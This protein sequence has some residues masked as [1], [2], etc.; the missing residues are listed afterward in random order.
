MRPGKA[1]C[2][3]PAAFE[4]LDVPEAAAEVALEATEERDEA[5]LL[6]E[7]R[8]L[9]AEAEASEAIDD[10]DDAAP[11]AT[12]EAPEKM[13]VDP[14]IDVKVEP[15]EVMMDSMADVVTADPTA[16]VADATAEEALEAA[17]E[18]AEVT[19]APT[20]PAPK[21]VVEPTVEVE[22]A[23]S[24][25]RMS[26]VVMAED[27]SAPEEDPEDPEDPA[28]AAVSVTV[29]VERAEVMRVV[30]VVAA[31]FPPAAAAEQ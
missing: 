9:E 23:E 28:P 10:K 17:P 6:A 13:V 15:P 19:E 20:P 29:A 1:V 18:A 12:L 26:E 25:V 30:R 2:I 14:R 4:V 8:T 16:S 7:L 11:L 27:D 22:P 3:A 31:E 21:I 5:T 24:V